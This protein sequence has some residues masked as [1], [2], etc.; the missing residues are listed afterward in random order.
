MKLLSLSAIVALTT[1]LPEIAQAHGLVG[2]GLVDGL[3]HPVGGADHLLAMV[4]VGLVSARIGGASLFA[5][6]GLFLVAMVAGF[7]LATQATGLVMASEA[8]ILVSVVVLGLLMLAPEL[9]LRSAAFLA[10]ALFGLCHGYAHGIELPATAS[11]WLY[12]AGFVAVSAGLHVTGVLLGKV[13][14]QQARPAVGFSVAG[15]AIGLSGLALVAM[16]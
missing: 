8:G 9:M 12:T 7:A 14:L 10:T 6:P 2:A 5:L 15:M 1:G 11:P 16:R 3:V 4:A 13:F